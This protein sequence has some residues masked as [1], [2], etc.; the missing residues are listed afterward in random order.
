MVN[1]SKKN[2]QKFETNKVCFNNSCFKKGKYRAPK[3]RTN[4]NHY[5]WFC[6][7]HIR[8]Y[9][10]SW[11]YYEG[12]NEQQIEIDIRATTTWE[13]PTWP[14]NGKNPKDLGYFNIRFETSFIS[15]NYL[16][17][18]Q[19]NNFK[20]KE[21]KA[22]KKL[23]INPTVD[24]DLIKTAYKKLVKRFHPDNNGGEKIYEE[25]LRSIIEAYSLLKK[26][27]E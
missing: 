18:P 20:Q 24:I 7:E 22:F 14:I 19:N 25:K 17:V 2:N 12:M 11:N 9:N 4:L 21:I 13:R 8:E 16:N 6:L 15:E 27:L 10:K 23:E 1:I 26:V 5:V 3:S